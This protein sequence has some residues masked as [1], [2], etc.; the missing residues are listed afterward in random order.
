LNARSIGYLPPVRFLIFFPHTVHLSF[1]KNCNSP[2]QAL[3]QRTI[4]PAPQASH[5]SP[6]K[7]WPLQIGHVT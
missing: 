7:V 4:S 3:V 6:A 5:C 1:S 2:Q